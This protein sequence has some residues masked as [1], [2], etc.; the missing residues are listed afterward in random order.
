MLV[1]NYLEHRDNQK[2]SGQ[3]DSEPHKLMWWPL[4]LQ[5][6]DLS[7]IISFLLDWLWLTW[8]TDWEESSR[9]SGVLFRKWW[10]KAL[11]RLVDSESRGKKTKYKG[12]DIQG[13]RLTREENEIQGKKNT[14]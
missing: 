6:A 7:S 1:P 12:R 8:W 9:K 10:Q 11:L 14:R 4:R 13:R 3:I 2:R 5:H